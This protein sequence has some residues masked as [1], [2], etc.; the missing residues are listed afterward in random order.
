M[1]QVVAAIGTLAAYDAETGAPRWAAPDGGDS[2][3]S[4]HLVTLDG[5]P[6]VLLLTADGVTS[7]AP[8]DGRVLWTHDWATTRRIVQPR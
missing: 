2:Y 4:P 7:V 6:Q 1:G 3:S 5:V 8:A